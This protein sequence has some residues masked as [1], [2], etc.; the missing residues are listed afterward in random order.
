[1]IA[2]FEQVDEELIKALLM[3]YLKRCKY[4]HAF[5]F[6]QFRRLLPNPDTKQLEEIFDNRKEH[7]LNE[8]E[9]LGL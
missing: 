5:A 3:R 9:R 2:Q 4:K 7:L 1:M 8:L 6:V